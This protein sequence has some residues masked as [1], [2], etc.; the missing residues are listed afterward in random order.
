MSIKDDSPAQCGIWKLLIP[1]S[2][3]FTK[4]CIGH[5]SEFV[6]ND[7]GEQTKTRKQVDDEF[8]A[9]MLEVSER[10]WDRIVAYTYY[11]IAR[12]LGGL[13]W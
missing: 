2:E 5:D 3:K 10:S 12:A 11:W 6:F 1:T 7:T 9:R 13:F 4:A 8:L